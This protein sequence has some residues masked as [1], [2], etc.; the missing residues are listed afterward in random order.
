[1]KG[2]SWGA[3][4]VLSMLL[5]HSRNT[6]DLFNSCFKREHFTCRK[7]WQPRSA[8]KGQVR[9]GAGTC[10]LQPPEQTFW[11]FHRRCPQLRL[12]F[13]SGCFPPSLLLPFQKHARAW[14]TELE[15]ALS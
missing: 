13:L 8:W 14:R 7:F 6:S 2:H 9:V 1:M 15:L 11:K 3:R 12:C 4:W 10:R 5:R